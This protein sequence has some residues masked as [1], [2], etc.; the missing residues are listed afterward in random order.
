MPS[1]LA[2]A[3]LRAQAVKLHMQSGG[4]VASSVAGSVATSVAGLLATP[5]ADS[6]ADSV[7]GTVAD[8]SRPICRF[9]R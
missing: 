3:R 5:V 8:H 7:A 1:F 2:A 9:T 4:S 6:V